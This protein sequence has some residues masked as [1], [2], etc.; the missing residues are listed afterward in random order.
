MGVGRPVTS[1]N[2]SGRNGRDPAWWWKAAATALFG[3]LT[4]LLLKG[5]DEWQK[6]NANLAQLT[7]DVKYQ[8]DR[9]GERGARLD[10]LERNMNLL[11]ERTL[12][13][14]EKRREV[15]ERLV[16]QIDERLDRLERFAPSQRQAP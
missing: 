12:V 11:H 8:I 1:S 13:E 9:V 7:A 15:G 3:M 2:D 4:M 14:F 10:Q 5:C 16:N 6:T